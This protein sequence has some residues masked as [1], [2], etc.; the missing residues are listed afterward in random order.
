[1]LILN[2]LAI[3]C[4]TMCPENAMNVESALVRFAEDIIVACVDKYSALAVVLIECQVTCADAREVLEFALT[5]A[6]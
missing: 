5:A 1:M 6:E 2:K 3:G 4:P